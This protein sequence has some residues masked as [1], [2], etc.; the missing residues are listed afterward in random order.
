[1]SDLGQ[2][3]AIEGDVSSTSLSHERSV[4]TTRRTLNE[5]F[6]AWRKFQQLIRVSFLTVWPAMRRLFVPRIHRTWWVA[7]LLCL[8]FLLTGCRDPRQPKEIWC[9]TGTGP[10]QV[11]YPRAITYDA[12]DDSFFIID[13]MA[14]IQH[15]DRNGKFIADWQMPEWRIGKPVGVSVGPDGNLYVPDT[16]YHRVMVYSPDG[17]LLRMWGTDGKG[18]SEFIY[19]TDVAW[20]SKGRLLVSEYGDNDRVQVFDPSA[21]RQNSSINSENSATAMANFPGRNRC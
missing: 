11:V 18:P 14:R 2:E 4:V 21:N 5:S 3:A 6:L 1:M 20:D 13:R 8:A 7:P 19:P 15:L 9:E 12:I 17:K 10:L 16:H